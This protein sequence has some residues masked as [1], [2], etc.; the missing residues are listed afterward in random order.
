MFTTK[1][2]GLIWRM[3]RKFGISRRA[4]SAMRQRYLRSVL[5]MLICEGSDVAL[6]W[7]DQVEQEIAY[8]KEAEGIVYTKGN[9]HGN[10]LT[11]EMID[12]ARNTS[13]KEVIDYK[14][15][16]AYAWCH[17]DKNPS[18]TYMSRTGLA[19]CPACDI[20][21]DAIKVLMERDKLSFPDAV[22]QLK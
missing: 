10:K 9:G 20:Y 3:A 6:H 1:K 4:A 18:L 7:A 21:F 8:L 17:E 15:G 5:G 13:T 12:N 11:E 16:K 19:W 2:K 22:K 14:R